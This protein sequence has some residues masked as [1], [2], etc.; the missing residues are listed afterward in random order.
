M[1]HAARQ[2]LDQATSERAFP[3]AVIEVGTTGQMLWREAFG[4]LTYADDAPRTTD[5]TIFDL[6]SLTKSHLHNPA[7]DAAARAR[8]ARA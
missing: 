1:F 5:D 7:G 4:R 6:A 2:L 8:S 3:A